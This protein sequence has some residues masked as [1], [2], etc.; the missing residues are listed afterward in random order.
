MGEDRL[1]LLPARP[2]DER[3]VR[4]DD[5]ER[6]ADARELHRDGGAA[7]DAG[8]R[9]V[10]GEDARDRP[11]R[12]DRVPDL[13][14]AVHA[15]RHEG[16][17]EA[18]RLGEPLERVGLAEGP[19]HLLEGRH[20]GPD[21][22]ITKP[23]G[24]VRRA[25]PV[26]PLPAVNVVGAT[27]GPAQGAGSQLGARTA[28]R[29]GSAASSASRLAACCSRRARSTPRASRRKSRRSRRTRASSAMLLRIRRAAI[30]EVDRRAGGS[31]RA[32]PS[33][34]RSDRIAD[35]G[36]RGL[37]SGRRLADRGRM[38][39]S[40]PAV[41]RAPDCSTPAWG[42]LPARSRGATGARG[43]APR[44]RAAAARQ[45]QRSRPTPSPRLEP[46]VI[47]PS[48]RAGT[49]S[50]LP[51]LASDSTSTP[52]SALGEALRAREPA[53]R[54]P[55]R[56]LHVRQVSRSRLPPRD[57]RQRLEF[58]GAADFFWPDDYVLTVGWSGPRAG[59]ARP[60][61]LAG[62][63]PPLRRPR[64]RRSGRSSPAPGAPYRVAP[65]RRPR[66]HPSVPSGG[67][68][69]CSC[70]RR[71]PARKA[72][73]RDL[74]RRVLGCREDAALGARAPSAEPGGRGLLVLPA[75]VR[76]PPREGPASAGKAPLRRRVRFLAA[77]RRAAPGR[78]PAPS[79]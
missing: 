47:P 48:R 78:D 63:R 67:T 50:T 42:S 9:E 25:Y 12:E 3:Q 59:G 71:L 33:G 19:E 39:P 36:A 2:V 65:S 51:T 77:A 21:L 73:S 79:G 20:V 74:P 61:T 30:E 26:Q 64:S 49:S 34:P 40:S 10:E 52:R 23:A 17:V 76:L 22:V 43:R 45:W 24:G 68:R 62:T 38:A 53:P 54:P 57:A 46:I 8:E 32:T 41:R 11:A 69:H 75:G 13:A 70:P 16:E 28:E 4:G 66:R 15:G 7:L 60:P 44:E 5:G 18:Q 31:P 35:G 14:E 55:L 6:A 29:Y 27:S 1:H 72:L 37:G 58:A 56:A